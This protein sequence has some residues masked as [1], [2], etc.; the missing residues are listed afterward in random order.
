MS[1]GE[2]TQLRA[3]RTFPPSTAQIPLAR[4]FVRE[5]LARWGEQRVDDPVVRDLVLM[6][7]ELFTNAVL[8]GRGDVEV[9]VSLTAHNVGVAVV[10]HG[11]GA[12]PRLRVALPDGSTNGH[13][14]RIVD[15]LAASWG[16]GHGQDGGTQ[17]W[18]EVPRS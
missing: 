8:H 7:S 10:D 6:V 1:A 17:V 12:R 16:T 14:L 3:S 9:S 5:T 11:R 2:P 15:R 4:L 18:L 13:G